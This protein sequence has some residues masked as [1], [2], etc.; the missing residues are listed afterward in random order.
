MNLNDNIDKLP[1]W[2]QEEVKRLQMR[3]KEAKEELQRINDN[4]V[5]NTIIG[6]DYQFPGNPPVKYLPNN[7][8]IMF[9]LPKGDVQCRIVGDCFEVHT[10]GEGSLFIQPKVSNSIL[11]HLI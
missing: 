3:L 8:N 11:I 2:A 4:P 7:Q 9:K 10:Q 1:K 5:S 6:H